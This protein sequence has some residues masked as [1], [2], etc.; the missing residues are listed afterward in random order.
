MQVKYLIGELLIANVLILVSKFDLEAVNCT[1]YSFSFTIWFETCGLHK[2]DQ[3]GVSYKSTI[4]SQ[5]F[6]YLIW[7]LYLKN[8][9]S[10]VFFPFLPVLSILIILLY[11]LGKVEKKSQ[12]FNLISEGQ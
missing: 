11:N 9:R 8:S 4:L 3:V 6:K 5:V 2:N 12:K 1:D 7:K 10:R